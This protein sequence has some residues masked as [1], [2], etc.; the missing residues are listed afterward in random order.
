LEAGI[1]ELADSQGVFSLLVVRNGVL[2]VERYF[3]DATAGQ[4]RE[5]ASASK[6]VMSA[7]VGIAIDRGFIESVDETLDSLLPAPFESGAYDDKGD[8]TLRS[9]LTMSSGFSYEPTITQRQSQPGDVS[10]DRIL[11]TPLSNPQNV[12]TYNTGGVHLAS[13]IL[14]SKTGMSTCRFANEFLFAPTGIDPDWW[15]R[16]RDGIFTG[17]W[18]FYL[19]PRELARF[20]QLYLNEGTHEG[21]QV[22]SAEWVAESTAPRVYEVAGP[23]THYGYWWWTSEVA[24]RFMYSARGGGEQMI[25]VIPSLDMVVVTTSETDLPSTARFDSMSFL[26]NY[27]IPAAGG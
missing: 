2:V 4:S 11:A 9:L 27:V 24:G 16:D 19:T 25:Y 10:I 6:S 26:A 15:N 20:G 22:L 1:P 13:A 12:F 3:N 7:L 5:I 17:G 14:T 8:L 18:N 23:T 21:K